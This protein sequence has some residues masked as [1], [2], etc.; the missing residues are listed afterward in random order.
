MRRLLPEII[1]CSRQLR[2]AAGFR[3]MLWAKRLRA[4][5][6]GA[7]PRYKL[8]PLTQLPAFFKRPMRPYYSCIRSVLMHET[9]S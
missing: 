9:G 7:L 1:A 8:L 2:G 4:L 3:Q 6:T 5:A